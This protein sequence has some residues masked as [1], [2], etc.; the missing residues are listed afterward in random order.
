MCCW[1]P[2]IL[3]WVSMATPAFC[4]SGDGDW[5]SGF[6]IYSSTKALNDTSQAA[7]DEPVRMKNSY[8]WNTSAVFPLSSPALHYEA[9]P[10]RCSVHFSTDAASARRLRA[11]KEEL[12]YL[13]AIQRG[14]EA[15]VE[16]LV[17]F[18]GAELED[19]RYEDVI[20]ENVIGIQEDHKRCHEVVEKAEEDLEK[21]LE[22]DVLDNVARMHKIR[23]ESS[24]FE[25]MLRAA[26]DIANRLEI[27]SKTLQASFTS[28]QLKDIRIKMRH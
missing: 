20:R 28:R 27:S 1:M 5:G 25:D 18:V 24:S 26:A 15:V 23:E 9:Q 21:Q 2:L 14:N 3:A 7:G 17:Q 4:Q 11:Q 6:D 22:G 12:A 10:D 13:Q 16:N 19:Q 8:D